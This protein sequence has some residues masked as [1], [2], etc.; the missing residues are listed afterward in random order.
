MKLIYSLVKSIAG[1]KDLYKTFKD[2]QQESNESIYTTTDFLTNIES[3]YKK[4][5]NE[6]K[7]PTDWIFSLKKWYNNIKNKEQVSKLMKKISQNVKMGEKGGYD[8]NNLITLTKDNEKITKIF[9]DIKN[10]LKLG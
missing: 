8:I 10:G 4:E 2:F 6:T 1:L 3:T 5:N 9:Q 7:I